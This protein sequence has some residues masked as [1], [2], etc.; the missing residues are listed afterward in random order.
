MQKS[1]GNAPSADQLRALCHDGEEIECFVAERRTVRAEVRHGQLET[2]RSG[3]EAYAEVRLRR[4]GRLQRAAARSVDWR[5][6]LE[7][8]RSAPAVPSAADFS[9]SGEEEASTSVG[10]DLEDAE[11]R[12]AQSALRLRD[13][14]AEV[15]DGF[16]PQTTS[17]ISR[18]ERRIANSLGLETC[19]VNGTAQVSGGGRAVRDGDFHSVQRSRLSSAELP[20]AEPVAREAAQR[21][22]WGRRIAQ[23]DSGRYP[24]VLGPAVL[25]SLLS[26]VLARLSA[27]ALVAGTSPWLDRLGEKALSSLFTLQSDPFL[28]DGPRR[29]PRDD[30][31]SATSLAPLI[32]AGHLAGYVVD[33]E[34]A[35]RL[36]V[37]APG[38]AFGSEFGAMPTPRPSCLSVLPGRTSL[39][40]LLASHPRMLLLEG[41]IGARPTNPLRGELAGNAVGL[42]LLEGGEV[43]GRIKNAVVSLTAFDALDGGLLALGRQREW[44]AGGMLQVAPGIVPHALVAEAS[45][46]VRG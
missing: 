19:M 22:A 42:Y 43:I 45:V 29:G 33:R 24:I 18:V 11:R 27:P 17:E 41:W 6:L 36:A 16:L 14:L 1:G 44:V 12:A 40:D 10:A 15:G 39:P 2:V 20:D 13:L 26:P 8:A 32:D 34:A 5:G 25:F 35:A 31:G 7:E 37:A 9:G 28:P 30:E 4:G 23:V 3:S 46:A 21:Y 38:T